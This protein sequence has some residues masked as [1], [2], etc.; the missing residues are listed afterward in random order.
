LLV[1]GLLLALVACA[2]Q[3]PPPPAAAAP[4]QV[5]VVPP[6]PPAPPPPPP[7][8][9]SFDGLYKGTMSQTASTQ[10]TGALV[11]GGCDSDRPTS[12]RVKRGDVRIWYQN[13]N[14]HTLH[15]RGKIDPTG[16]INAWHTNRGG[17][18]AILAGQ[19]SGDT[20]N[21]DLNRGR[22]YYTV[23]LTKT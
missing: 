23:A 10:T 21:L 5:A 16:K 11:G 15:Y 20:A 2:Q 18:G 12:M 19:I 13:H 17:S 8:R 14:G 1:F 6:P 9:T 22:C 7:P 3:Q 4:P